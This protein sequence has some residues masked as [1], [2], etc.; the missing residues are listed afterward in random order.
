MSDKKNY[1]VDIK[2]IIKS[3]RVLWKNNEKEI[4]QVCYFGF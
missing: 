3:Y 1:L 2:R 4:W